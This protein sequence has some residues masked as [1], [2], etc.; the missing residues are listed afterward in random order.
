MHHLVTIHTLQ[1]DD[2]QTQGRPL[3][4]SA[5]MLVVIVSF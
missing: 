1:T 3:V 5:K 4:R 2:R